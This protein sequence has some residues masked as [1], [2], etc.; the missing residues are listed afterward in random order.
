MTIEFVTGDTG[1]KL[2][3]TCV[4]NS[5][6]LAID[7]TGA[8]VRLRWEGDTSVQTKVMTITDG[9]NGVAEYQFLAGEIIVPKMK[10]EVEITDSSGFVVT[11]LTL[12]EVGVREQ[13][14]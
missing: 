12:I 4:T 6:G 13:L 7:L 8:T 14:G 10:F 3:A 2:V 1:S 11:N 5:D 9:P